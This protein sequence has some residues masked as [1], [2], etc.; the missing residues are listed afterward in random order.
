MAGGVGTRNRLATATAVDYSIL[1]NIATVDFPPLAKLI[2]ALLHRN[3]ADHA[4][5]ARVCLSRIRTELTLSWKEP[6]PV[7]NA[8]VMDSGRKV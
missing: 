7:E 4:E 3:D 1:W 6:R 5:Q 2:R 8:V